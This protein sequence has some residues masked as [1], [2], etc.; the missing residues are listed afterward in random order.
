MAQPGCSSI[1]LC[2][3]GSYVISKATSLGWEQIKR[4]RLD[5]RWRPL[6]VEPMAAL[7]LLVRVCYACCSSQAI[8]G[9][10][11]VNATDP[12]RQWRISCV[13]NHVRS[14]ARASHHGSGFSSAR[15]IISSW[16]NQPSP[17]HPHPPTPPPSPNWPNWVV[18]N[19]RNRPHSIW[20]ILCWK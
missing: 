19:V 4:Q 7:S 12:E 17:S 5:A 9:G 3:Y 16:A 18:T 6:P 2:F 20:F 1:S 8:R 15:L 11:N 14:N 13:V 10:V